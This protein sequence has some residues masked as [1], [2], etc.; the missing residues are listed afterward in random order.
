MSSVPCS[1][2]ICL[3]TISPCASRRDANKTPLV[4][5]EESVSAS[6][7]VAGLFRARSRLGGSLKL[8]LGLAADRGGI[9]QRGL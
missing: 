9:K 3:P 8:H 6:D 4:G 1:K 7:E 5:Q 2:S